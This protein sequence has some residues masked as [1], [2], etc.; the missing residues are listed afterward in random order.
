MVSALALFPAGDAPLSALLPP[1]REQ[2]SE[3]LARLD[4]LCGLAVIA[5]EACLAEV[6][7]GFR[8]QAAQTA[9][10]CG[11]RDGCLA[12]DTAFFRGALAGEASPRLF[13]YTLHS[14]PVGAVS[15][16]H[17]LMGPGST[18]VGS[19]V[20]G[21]HAL[22]EA[23]LL[24]STGQAQAAV[25]LSCD[26]AWDRGRDALAVLYLVA[27]SSLPPHLQR[28]QPSQWSVLAVRSAFVAG[29]PGLARSQVLDDLRACEPDLAQAV[30]LTAEGPPLAAVAALHRDPAR[31]HPRLAGPDERVVLMTAEDPQ[32][33]A[34]GVVLVREPAVG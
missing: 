17:G 18:A 9:V 33:Y 16:Q 32:G 8:A 11:T 12:T 3:G 1:G 31:L 23:L 22:E 15:I 25:V 4:R 10:L 14:A 13:A 20:A 6:G 19:P 5:S 30:A 24:L 27:S 7:D 34:A 26:V 2:V 21:L 28:S 29:Q